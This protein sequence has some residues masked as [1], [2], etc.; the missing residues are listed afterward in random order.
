VLSELA[1]LEA[2]DGRSI[3]DDLRETV[4]QR[5]SVVTG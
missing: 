4:V 5:G 2:G 3:A 1:S